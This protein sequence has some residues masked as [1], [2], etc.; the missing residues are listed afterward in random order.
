MVITMDDNVNANANVGYI[1]VPQLRFES[2]LASTQHYE[3][4]GHNALFVNRLL[5]TVHVGMHL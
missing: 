1:I 3:P 4:I 2:I 5:Q